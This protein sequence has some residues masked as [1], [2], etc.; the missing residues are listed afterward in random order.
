M[1]AKRP[2]T[3]LERQEEQISKGHSPLVAAI[4]H[5]LR[6]KHY[7]PVG[8]DQWYL[9]IVL[10]T[11]LSYL[12]LRRWP[13]VLIGF[14]VWYT[15]ENLMWYSVGI[16]SRGLRNNL[17]ATESRERELLIDPVVFLLTLAISVYIFD[18]SVVSLGAGATDMLP[19]VLSN[20][21][22]I[23]AAI[24]VVLACW[25]G[26]IRTFWITLVL[27]LAAIWIIFAV[28][29]G[30]PL[31]LWLAVRASGVVIFYY[32]WFIRPIARH[33]LYNALFAVMYVLLVVSI[34][35]ISQTMRAL[36]F[37]TAL[38]GG[39]ALA[40]MSVFAFHH[41][42]AVSA[43][44]R[45]RKLGKGKSVPSAERLAADFMSSTGFSPRRG[46]RSANL[47]FFALPTAYLSYYNGS[48]GN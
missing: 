19:A 25:S 15:F 26:F 33:F 7:D 32:A 2:L 36:S 42:Q 23:R 31:Q 24:V 37:W 9:A 5:V 47:L 30:S 12:Y 29:S 39:I 18:Y 14:V 16:A 46:F 38:L 17:R 35:D 1:S 43:R 22:W 8:Y 4:A 44:I 48:S 21:D 28:D 20:A 3:F 45:I 6:D 40:L 10:A 34:V 27:L 41:D 11:T 13:L